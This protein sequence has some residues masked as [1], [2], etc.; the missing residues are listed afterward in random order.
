MIVQLS[1]QSGHIHAVNLR[2]D[3][4]LKR[5]TGADHY[6]SHTRRLGW[7]RSAMGTHPRVQTVLDHMLTIPLHHIGTTLV[8]VHDS[9]ATPALPTL[10]ISSRC[11][12]GATVFSLYHHLW[13]RHSTVVFV[14]HH[15]WRR[16]SS[17]SA[18]PHVVWWQH[19]SISAPPP[20][21][22]APL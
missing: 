17:I 20:S 22:V 10:T 18:P 5:S 9:G 2:S 7:P 15:K 3:V 11:V 16:H 14:H 1:H 4:T 19:S 8:L 13:G 6:D 12:G 21:V